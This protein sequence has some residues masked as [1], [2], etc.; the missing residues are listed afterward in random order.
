[1]DP[2]APETLMTLPLQGATVLDLTNVMSGPYCTLMLADMGADVIK[3]ESFPEGDMSRRF[4]PKVNGE[5]YCFAVLNRNKRSVALNLKRPEGLD[6]F[7]RLAKDAHF[8]V[9]NFRPDVKHKIGI[10]YEAVK[11][12]NPGVIYGSVSGFGQTGPY[13]TKG[14]YDIVAQGVTGIMRMTGEPG[15]RPAKVGIAMNDIAAGATLLYALLG[16][17]IHRLKTGEGQY[18]ETSLVEAG[19]AW[20]FWEFGAYFGAGEAPIA[21]GTRHR[22]SAPY[23]AYRTKDGYVTVGANN[24]KLWTDF[25]QQVVERPQWLDDPR[26]VD[27]PARLKN[28]D[29]LQEEIEAVFM[30]RET[31]YWWERLDRAGV[32][33]GPVYTYEQC[34]ADPHVVARRMVVDVE[35]PRIGPMKAMGH[36][37]K[38]SGDIASIRTPAPML[39]Q[40][41]RAVLGSLGY[42]ETEIR[43]MLDNGAAFEGAAA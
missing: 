42:S 27:L 29:A 37:V 30:Q 2:P 38:S 5:S 35:H 16:A 8:I 36:P 9:E 13:A 3:I 12:I 32:P 23:Q 31:A 18:V 1:M 14:G 11:K 34:L 41:T 4:D 28:V 15:G 24:T 33:G 7:R 21:T 20:T 22:R 10:D 26:F 25:C 40:H 39:G 43:A 17:Y 6:A 19:L